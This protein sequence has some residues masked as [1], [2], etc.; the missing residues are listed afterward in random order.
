L[1]GLTV[2]TDFLKN[3]NFSNTSLGGLAGIEGESS[4]ISADL[5]LDLL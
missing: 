4:A 3:F 5:S 1:F 2:A